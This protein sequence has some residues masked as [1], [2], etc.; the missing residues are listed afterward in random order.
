MNAVN[1]WLS[2]PEPVWEEAPEPA[3]RIEALILARDVLA[4][5]P[6]VLQ[7]IRHGARRRVLFDRAV[8]IDD[9]PV[10]CA[11]GRALHD[12]DE[13]DAA[14]LMTLAQGLWRC[15]ETHEALELLMQ[16]QL[17]HPDW[18][19]AA[20]LYQQIGDWFQS[21]PAEV[22]SIAAG[23]LRLELLG[24]QHMADY[25]WQYTDPAIAELCCLPEFG[26]EG[27]WHTWLE[28][29]LATPDLALYG[30]WHCHW[31]FVGCV[32][33]NLI[34]GLGFFHY[35]IGSDFR[36]YG[37]GPQAGEALLAHAAENWDMSVCYAKVFDHNHASQRGLARIGFGDT[38]IPI[39]APEMA[40]EHLLCWPG[41]GHA[42]VE[43]VRWL[44]EMLD[45]PTRVMA[46]CVA[47]V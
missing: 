7:H 23:E 31:G 1:Q 25:Q 20:E 22:W 30:I 35:W 42:D 13:A 8:E 24:H 18:A 45:G 10:I 12:M 37:F 27:E 28:H 41:V 4:A 44:F 14:D 36:G 5:H 43:Q 9:V 11:V 15:G 46:P 2:Q 3:S 6:S 21:R 19:W 33:L 47:T 34:Q 38:G 26:C 17:R 40:A 16:L 32:G 29:N 39:A